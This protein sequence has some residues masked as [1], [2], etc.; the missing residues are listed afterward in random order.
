M[1]LKIEDDVAREIINI[2]QR[3]LSEEELD[4]L[5]VEAQETRRVENKK[6]EDSAKDKKGLSTRRG[7]WMWCALRLAH[8]LEWRGDYCYT[9]DFPDVWNRK[10]P[11]DEEQQVVVLSKIL[12]QLCLEEPRR[13]NKKDFQVV[14]KRLVKSANRL[15]ETINRVNGIYGR[16]RRP[17]YSSPPDYNA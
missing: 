7:L 6:Q 3:D 15:M 16:G 5:L 9:K 12:D 14:Y 10:D 1:K 4:E 13:F 11:D 2:L 8:Q 17:Y